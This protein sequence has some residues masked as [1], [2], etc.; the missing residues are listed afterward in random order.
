MLVSEV[1]AQHA[2]PA[3]SYVNASQEGRSM[4]SVSKLPTEPKSCYDPVVAMAMSRNG[5]AVLEKRH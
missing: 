2:A 5:H 1:G 3:E 4:E